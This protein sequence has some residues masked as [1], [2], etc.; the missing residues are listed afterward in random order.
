MDVDRLGPDGGQG[1][2]AGS[3]INGV[4]ESGQ[5]V[6]SPLWDFLLSLPIGV[7]RYRLDG[8]ER[9][10]LAGT[11]EAADTILGVPCTEL[12]GSSIGEVFPALSGSEVEEHFLQVA[13]DGGRWHAEYVD[14]QDER[15]RGVYQV[16]AQQTSPGEMAVL[17]T[18]ISAPRQAEEAEREHRLELQA[19]S[20][21]VVSH[22]EEERRKVSQQLQ[23][24]VAQNV[25]ALGIKLGVVAAM[26]PPDTDPALQAQVGESV[27]L[28]GQISASLRT[29]TSG[30]RPPVLDD[31]GLGASLRWFA[32]PLAEQVGLDLELT[33]SD[34]DPRLP[35][36]T[37]AALFR[38]AEEALLNVA[39]HAEATVVT[40]V[41]EVENDLVRLVVADDGRGFEPDRNRRNGCQRNGWGLS[42]MR[43]RA[44]SAGGRLRI[45]SSPGRGT[46]V[47]VEVER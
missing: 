22:H 34:A 9:L 44:E 43:E 19:L 32:Q 28:I 4:A 45:M 6:A 13:A 40:V 27:A 46:R 16:C 11:N 10:V 26:L 36:A 38:I 1:C 25:A 17:F 3:E 33:V 37:E 21:R 18:D 24:E 47:V 35:A 30:L 29:L 41:L 7:L 12:V 39:R 5:A 42:L 8:D 20:A 23:D 15:I 2:S 31:C 14:Y